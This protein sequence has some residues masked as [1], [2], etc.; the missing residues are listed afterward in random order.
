MKQP[1][2]DTVEA[3]GASACVVPEFSADIIQCLRGFYYTAQT[4]SMTAA[5]SL[6]KR[7]QSTLSHQIRNLEQELGVNLFLGSKNRR[8]LTEEGKYLLQQVGE[9]A[10][11][12]NN[13]GLQADSARSDLEGEISVTSLAADSIV[14]FADRLIDFCA[15]HPKVRFLHHCETD[16]EA[17]L[18]TLETGG[19][20]F[21]LTSVETIPRAFESLAFCSSPFVLA[22][23]TVGPYALDETP[24]LERL[25]KLPL[26]APSPCSRL[27]QNLVRQLRRHNCELR[28]AHV[29]DD[30]PMRLQC[31][32][33]G[34]GVT[35]LDE[36]SC[37]GPFRQQM[38]LL[39]LSALMPPREYRLIWRGNLYLQPH[40]KVFLG[41]FTEH[42]S[43][44]E[45]YGDVSYHADRQ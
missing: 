11:V 23:P 33:A 40:L 22:V 8:T 28:Y 29:I 1:A 10:R 44:Q 20:H 7:S 43:Q 27:W 36:A 12:L 24:T 31:V 38:R 19:V 37:L 25:V 15:A 2:R 4:G 14:P 17:M 34:L 42:F 45:R 32:A 13:L 18:R 9:L 41:S 35:I 3:D 5:S 30:R 39:P 21:A 26:L 16:E 6:M